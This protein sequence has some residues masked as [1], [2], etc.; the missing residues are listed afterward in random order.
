MR[1][2]IVIVVILSLFIAVGAMSVYA[3]DTMDKK[4]VPAQDKKFIKDAADSGN[5]E[6]ELGK[7]AEKKAQSQD[8]KDFGAMMVNDH[9]KADNELKTLA[10]EKDVKLTTQLTGKPKAV[11]TEVSK[12]TG[13]DFDKKYMREMVKDHAED[14]A[15]F[16]KASQEV[17]DPDVKSWVDKTLPVLQHHFKMAKDTAQKLGVDVNQAEQEGRSAAGRT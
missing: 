11:V 9:K 8:V 13:G 15:K 14:L 1:T 2:P 17:K 16:E 6:V 5:M 10:K 3:A 4:S 12:F 7:L